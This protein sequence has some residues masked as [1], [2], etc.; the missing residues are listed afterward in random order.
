V[1]EFKKTP[2]PICWAAR[3][4]G[5]WIGGALALDGDSGA[6]LAGS[7]H[8]WPVLAVGV[9]AAWALT[10]SAPISTRFTRKEVDLHAWLAGQLGLLLSP[11]LSSPP[12][13]FPL[14]QAGFRLRASSCGYTCGRDARSACG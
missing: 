10:G 9:G 12:Y 6:G 13:S 7:A 3:L 2:L 8:L 14:A 4:S 1:A 11:A 5:G